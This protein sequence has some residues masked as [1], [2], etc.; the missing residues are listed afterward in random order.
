MDKKSQPEPIAPEGATNQYAP[1][2]P[3]VTN[4]EP[5]GQAGNGP[6]RDVCLCTLF[7]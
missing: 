2:E 7:P 1:Q 4:S 3:P 5:T 6:S